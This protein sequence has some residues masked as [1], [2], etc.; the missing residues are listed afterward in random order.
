MTLVKVGII[1]LLC[2]AGIHEAN[3]NRL[4]RSYVLAFVAFVI[5]LSTSSME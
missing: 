5:A 4:F 1:V 2:C 3:E